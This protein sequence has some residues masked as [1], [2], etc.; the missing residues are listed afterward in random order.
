[1]PE[2]VTLVALAL[3]FGLVP[4]APLSP[5]TAQPAFQVADLGHT[6]TDLLPQYGFSSSAVLL[7][8]TYV[9]LDDGIHGYELWRSDGTAAGT[10]LVKDL[11]PGSCAGASHLTVL[12][13]TLYFAGNDGEVN[14]LFK[15]DGTAAGTV[16]VFPKA[17]TL[18]QKGFLP[19]GTAG[20]KLLLT[21]R[22][23]ALDQFELWSTDGTEAGTALVQRLGPI[24]SPSYLPGPV[25]LGQV[26]STLFFSVDDGVHG[27]EPWK[28]D[29]T[30]AGTALLKDIF[31][32]SGGSIR[33]TLA[34]DPQDLP[35]IGGALVFSA[36]DDTQGCQLW[37][38]DGTTAGTTLVHVLRAGG[39]ILSALTGWNGG[40][41]FFSR[42]ASGWILFKSDGTDAGTVP[43]GPSFDTIGEI[44]VA[45]PRIFFTANDITN[46]SRLWK[47]DGADA[48]TTT[49]GSIT[50]SPTGNPIDVQSDL[51]A[52][53]GRVVLFAQNG[54][55]GVEPWGSDGTDAG[56]VLL[57]DVVPG[58]D[59]SYGFPGGGGSRIF[60]GTAGKLF[61]TALGPDGWELWGSDGTPAGTSEIQPI[62][63]QTPSLALAFESELL[64][65]N[66]T[67]LFTPFDAGVSALWK[68]DGTSAGTLPV[69]QVPDT[70]RFTR[71]NGKAFFLQQLDVWASD[72]TDAGTG[73]FYHDATT[74]ATSLTRWGNRLDF[75]V[76]GNSGNQT[77]VQLWQ[78]DGGA[79]TSLVK[80]IVPESFPSEDPR[81][82]PT[83][84]DLFFTLNGSL[85]GDLWRTDGTA[86]GTV[87]VTVPGAAATLFAPGALLGVSSRLFFTAHGSTELW[88]SDG[89]PAGT[90]KL[91]TFQAIQETFGLAALGGRLLFAADDGAHG[92][93]PWTTD[94]T[95]AGTHL[96]ADVN[97]GADGSSPLYLT[98]LLG[99]VYFTADDGVHGRELW[100][101]D[102][103]AAGTHMIADLLPGPGS[104]LPTQL[105]AIGHLLFFAATDSVHSVEP[106]RSDGTAAG[107]KMV[108]DI[109]P[110]DLPSSPF[111][112][113][114]S[115]PYVYFAANDGTHGT[116]L[117]ALPRAAL[118]GFLTATMTASDRREEARPM[119][120]TLVVTNVG[121]GP[122]GDNPGPEVTDTLP[123]GVSVLSAT[124]DSGTVTV[125]AGQNRIDWNGSLAPGASVTILIQARVD[126]LLG[127]VESNQ[128]TLAFDADGDGDGT[129][130]SSGVSDDPTRPGTSDPTTFSVASGP[131][132]FYRVPLCRAVDTRGIDPL[133]AGTPQTFTIGGTCNV[134]QTAR[135]IAVNLTVVVPSTAGF[136]TVYPSHT[137]APLASTLNFSRAQTRSNN[138]ILPLASFG[139][140][141]AKAGLPGGGQLDLVVDVVGYFQ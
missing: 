69:G 111:G 113:T 37:K 102:G 45:G 34:G 1:M 135:A 122:Q 50:T 88:T 79:N 106:W 68:S 47:S 76:F 33:V 67:L 97:P 77:N 51:T 59:G 12:G 107:T 49:V 124:A 66:G 140:F 87:P 22:N 13:S 52:V 23:T 89:T 109:A 116:E 110:G 6:V 63:T 115:G 61:L 27:R 126:A 9:V 114:A 20:G 131:L 125:N 16:P 130:E 25:R 10:G 127:S 112:F 75:V 134:P 129:N 58:V 55:Q 14:T 105:T 40:V 4:V 26:G 120:Y 104:A 121:A 101:S 28:T 36:C 48:D 19:F 91:G 71:L 11:C 54:T 137:A 65:L 70:R 32:G 132:G 123:I 44:A 41:V 103:T 128:A 83:D 43:V 119:T 81:F 138:A 99:R 56:T 30:S 80:T 60:A 5:L 29:G 31:P 118:G 133:V 18:D 2:I 8:V 73:V 21:S 82:A 46:G 74:S 15:T 96:V 35:S 117:W 62:D 53:G 141:D 57:A 92:L 24:L 42:Q 84:N 108:Q 100:G 95:A 3:A 94:G 136:L 78:S 98:P 139:A 64:D 17:S 93:E 39:A 86:A 85:A 90:V 7:G 72:G 38:S